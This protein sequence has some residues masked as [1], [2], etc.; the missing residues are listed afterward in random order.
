MTP[1]NPEL[2]TPA[3]RRG[4]LKTGALLSGAALSL[5]LGIS[6]AFA[7]G[8]DTL[9]IGLVGCGGRGT[10]AAND[11]MTADPGIKLVAMGDVFRDRLDASRKHLSSINA[12]QVDVADDKCFVGFDAYQKVI[13]CDVDLVL[14]ATPP[15]FRSL[16]LE[17]AIEA[18][19]HVF[20]EKPVAVDP[21]TARRVMKAAIRAKEQNL[22]IVSGTQRRHE[23]SYL[24]T[25]KRIEDGAIGDVV[26]AQCYWN[27]GG[28]WC[29]E[30]KSHYSD[31]E[32]QIRNWL[33]FAW[34]SGDHIVEQ[35]IH[36]IDVVN[37]AM[38]GPPEKAIG[39]GGRQVRTDP[40][41]GHI[42][43]HFAIEYQY[44][45]GARAHSYCRQQDGAKGEVSER[46]VGT[47]GT[48]NPNGAIYG[49]QAW[50]FSRKKRNNPYVQ[51]HIDLIAGIREG[52]PLNEGQRVAEST[53][54]AIMGRIAA[55]TGKQVT[56]EHMTQSKLSLVPDLTQF[57]DLPVPAIPMPGKTPLE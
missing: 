24:E 49:A 56:W 51:E 19:K 8:S 7:R 5:P 3:S 18:G 11:C 9:R 16:H 23:S 14:F 22:S 28:L 27:Q 35:H 21:V 13:A 57:G 47:K 30:R 37:W 42:F 36:N 55:Y 54:T 52:N 45:S 40:K 2:L 4:F 46:L 32:W 44:E 20:A 38:G 25:M 48:S 34:L 39:L 17:A 12:S 6:G 50:K 33:Y 26:S 29:H 31:V 41:Y 10:G 15:A 53:L 43:D 1:N